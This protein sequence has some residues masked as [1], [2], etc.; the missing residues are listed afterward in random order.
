MKPMSFVSLSTKTS[1]L[2]AEMVGSLLTLLMLA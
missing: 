2:H 1:S